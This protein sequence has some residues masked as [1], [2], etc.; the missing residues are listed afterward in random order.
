M[1]PEKLLKMDLSADCDD[2]QNSAVKEDVSDVVKVI[3]FVEKSGL[4]LSKVARAMSFKELKQIKKSGACLKK[5]HFKVVTIPLQPHETKRMWKNWKKL[6]SKTKMSQESLLTAIK[7]MR[8]AGAD[9]VEHLLKVGVFLGQKI[10]AN[11]HPEQYV[12]HVVSKKGS[13]SMIPSLSISSSKNS[14]VLSNVYKKKVEKLETDKSDVDKLVRTALET[15]LRTHPVCV[16]VYLSDLKREAELKAKYPGLKIGRYST[17]KGGDQSK[18][19]KAWKK[20]LLKSGISDSTKAIAE[21][22]KIRLDKNSTKKKWKLVVIGSYLGRKLVL[23][24]GEYRHP[25]DVLNY[26]LSSLEVPSKTSKRAYSQKEDKIILGEV[27]KTGDN[28][29]TFDRIRELINRPKIAHIRRRYQILLKKNNNN[30]GKE[31][32]KVVK[33]PRIW[34]SD[35]SCAL[36]DCLMPNDSDRTTESIEAI[37]LHDIRKSGAD[38]ILA[39]RSL[40]SISNHWTFKLKPLLLRYHHGCH[41]EP[42]QASFLQYVIDNKIE[43]V[44]SLNHK[45]VNANFP[46][47]GAS[48]I[49][50]FLADIRLRRAH[51]DAK[52]NNPVHVTAKRVIEYYREEDLKSDD[53][54]DYS[55]LV[56]D[57]YCRGRY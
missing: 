37:K 8:D 18:V 56:V 15:E 51:G 26:T 34:S 9:H 16:K 42:W 6:A 52:T 23:S 53:K 44:K 38:K 32:E 27:A 21:L 48:V 17:C 25:V 30:K 54:N 47:L 24:H 36:I 14:L 4:A 41:D 1:G 12:K 43:S 31:S 39:P 40:Q 49:S 2:I 55:D 28:H 20:L 29:Q 33:L 22:A 11:R 45:D 19:L 46:G 50:K 57:H 35:E 13:A 5:K 7:S 10:E 3:R